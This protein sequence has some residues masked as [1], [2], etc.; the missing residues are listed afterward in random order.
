[1][2]YCVI[3]AGGCG[4]SIAGFLAR[5][6][7]NVV[8]IDRGE[9]LQVIREYVL[10]LRTTTFGTFC[11][12]LKA[13]TAEEYDEKPDVVFVCVKA[14]SLT[15]IVPFLR[16]ITRPQTVVIPI[17][18]IYGTGEQLQKELPEPLVTDGCI[19]I[20]AYKSEPGEIT[21]SS[22]IFRIVYGVRRP[23]DITPER[24]R[25]L[26]RAAKDLRE[27]QIDVTVSDAI[28]RDTLQ[29]YS[30]T[31]PMAACGLYYD[32]RVGAMQEAGEPRLLFEDL[33]REIEQLAMAMGEPLLTDAVKTNL[34]I[35]DA[36]QPDAAASVQRDI[37]AGRPSEIEELIKAPIRMGEAAGIEMPKYRMVAKKLDLI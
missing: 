37:W 11:V 2:K 6:G 10:T 9:H 19:Y 21:L 16:R 35:L 23:E 1:M 22:D 17:L 12:P 34:D 28:R 27:S 20:S 7:K 13:E 36:M 25:T 14:Y 31:S 15:D 30:F 24:G 4:G 26:L 33:V 29:K 5:A 32:I 8:L 3:G 18:N